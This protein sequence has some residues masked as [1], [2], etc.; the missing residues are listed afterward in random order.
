MK[1]GKITSKGGKF[2]YEKDGDYVTISG[3][4]EDASQIQDEYHSMEDLYQHR[5][6]LFIN[7]CNAYY[8]D[9]SYKLINSNWF[10]LYLN[11]PCGQISYHINMYNL[12]LLHKDILEAEPFI[13]DR[14]SSK[15]VI[16]RLKKMQ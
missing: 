1:I 10:V 15:D 9:A 14:H 6:L 12:N 4:V 5:N 16:E 13:F 3:L 2:S 11:R 8:K 7:L